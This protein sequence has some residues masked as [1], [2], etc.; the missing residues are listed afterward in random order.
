MTTAKT[1]DLRQST[2]FFGGLCT[3]AG[4]GGFVTITPAGERIT[5]DV[6]VKGGV[7]VHSNAPANQ[8]SYRIELTLMQGAL[9]SVILSAIAKVP[10]VVQLPCSVI[11]PTEKFVG[12]ATLALEPTRTATA[13]TTDRVWTFEAVGEI[14]DTAL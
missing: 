10:G 11:T 9:F 6:D 1:Y 2:F 4:K 5:K 8:R 14:Q 13:E 3:E 12:R 7:V